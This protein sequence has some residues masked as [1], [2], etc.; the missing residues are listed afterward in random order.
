MS[1]ILIKKR[2]YLDNSKYIFD[3]FE[4]KKNISSNENISSNVNTLNKFFCVK[5]EEN[6]EEHKDKINNVKKY[7][8]N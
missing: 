7:F 8:T 1:L 5:N 6:N 2:Y 3:Y 4:D